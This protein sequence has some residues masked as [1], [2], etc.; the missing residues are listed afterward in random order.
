SSTPDELKPQ[1][2]LAKVLMDKMGIAWEEIEDYEAD[3]IIGTLARLGSAEHEVLILTGDKD[4]FQLI[5]D[6]T[7]VMLTKKGITN[8]E[9]WNKKSLFEHYGLTP[10]LMIDLKALMGDASDNIPGIAGVGEKTALKL[11]KEFGTL[12]NVL[13]NAE[14][15]KANGLRS[16]V[17]KGRESALMSRKLAVIDRYMEDKFPELADLSRYDYE[18]KALQEN[19]ALVD[20][21]KKMNFASLLKTAYKP[22]PK[23]APKIAVDI[24]EKTEQ[25]V[26]VKNQ[27][28]DRSIG[29]LF[30][31]AEIPAANSS[32]D[33]E[34]L[35]KD[36]KTAGSFCVCSYN[37]M[38]GIQYNRGKRETEIIVVPSADLAAN[39]SLQRIFADENIKKTTWQGKSIIVNLGN[40]GVSVN[41]ICDDIELMAYLLNPVAGSYASHVLSAEYLNYA[42]VNEKEYAR[43]EI[44]AMD[45][46]LISEL[47]EVLREKLQENSL[48]ELYTEMEL[49]L[50]FVLAEMELN[51]ITVNKQVL[52]KLDLEL[53]SQE[54]DLTAKIYDLAGRSF[55]I[56]SP[57]QLGEVLFVEMGIPPVKKTKT[58]FSTNQEVL[59]TLT[60]DYPIA[61]LV[62]QYRSVSKLRS[63]YAVG[64]Q[65]LIGNDGK[66]HTSFNQTVTA[67]G[68]LSSTDPNLQNIPI[69][70]EIGRRLRQAFTPEPGNI[71]ISADY[72]QIELRVLAHISDDKVLQKSF[73]DGEDI[74]SR[75][76]AEVFGVNI[77]EVTREQRRRAKA[78]NFGIVYGISEYGLARDLKITRAEGKEYIEKYLDGYDGVRFYMKD[79]VEQG[80]AKG[81]VET[82]L[83]RKRWLPDLHNRNYNLRSFA[84]RTALNTPIQGTAADIMKIAMLNVADRLKKENLKTKMLLQVHDELIFDVP[85]AERDVMVKLVKEEME[86][87]FKLA[88]PMVAD[89]KEGEDWYNMRTVEV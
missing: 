13:A 23:V 18:N 89:V 66:I 58:G 43:E 31:S 41:G 76:A 71:L 45:A 19:R 79:I 27:E 51:G 86:N 15:I 8:V 24:S 55:N 30:A 54:A 34:D 32:I 48:L 85:L 20:F 3:D 40:L 5:N 70:E 9:V 62:L 16:K 11:L 35:A 12:D 42:A 63:T 6:H 4:S 64:L 50:S 46:G 26:S 83:G 53:S 73:I 17:L 47:S 1:F 2:E 67:T 49:P 59:E 74:H 75:T 78:V 21:Y 84:E 80:K 68:R 39:E 29:G 7:K 57:K 81:Y 82:L 72:S 52:Q 37:D 60:T 61:D 87:A 77:N 88:V 10:E 28:K 65:S 22:A 14:N 38:F 44:A 25:T 33:F 69:R 56:N 36:L